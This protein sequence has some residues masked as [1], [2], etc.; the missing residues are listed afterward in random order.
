MVKDRL[1]F[2]LLMD[3]GT[4]MLARNFKLQKVGNLE[5]IQDNYDVDAILYSIDEL[6][7]LNVDR[8]QKSLDTFTENLIELTKHCFMPVAAGGGIRSVED[9]YQI[10]NAGAD[11]II[12]NSTLIKDKKL[13]KDLV[14]IFGSQCIVASIDYK[15]EDNQIKTY[16][17]NATEDS[18]L[19]I[20]EAVNN[21][22]ELNVGEIYLNSIGREGTG[23]GLDIETV[24]KVTDI[25]KIPVIAA[26]GIERTD[27]FTQGIKDAGAQGV[28]ASDLLY[29][30]GDSLTVSRSS[31][32][33]DGCDMATW[34]NV[35]EFVN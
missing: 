3:N 18:G 7:V 21:A 35:S 5:W 30:M 17:N 31:M 32:Q 14:K 11:K 12:L 2:S 4:Y 27:Q 13:V 28:A 29:F 6:L 20:F 26:G 16:I 24:R 23:Q 8:E 34:E 9:A 1:I 15:I 22:I 25:C 19:D 10:I 33:E